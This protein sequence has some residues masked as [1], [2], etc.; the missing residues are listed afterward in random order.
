MK[1][2][3]FDLINREDLQQYISYTQKY[4]SPVLTD[5][6][7]EEIK[8]LCE[9]FS[10]NSISKSQTRNFE[11][12]YR[13]TEA[14]ARLES[15]VVATKEDVNDVMEIIKQSEGRHYFACE[16][17]TSTVSGRKSSKRKRIEGL[18]KVLEQIS[19]NQHRNEF[20]VQEIVDI[21]DTN[22]LGFNSSEEVL[23]AIELLN[24]RSVLIK[25]AKGVYRLLRQ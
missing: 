7:V 16:Y 11:V 20:S 1:S 14:R 17:L 24:E 25:K 23:E 10:V 5:D 2:T 15:R 6:A 18:H 22:R 8:A 3:S 19:D 13:L 12:L 21:C 9:E 4:I